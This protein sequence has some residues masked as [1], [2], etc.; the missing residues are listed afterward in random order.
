MVRP[1]GIGLD[2]LPRRKTALSIATAMREAEAA[3]ES[4]HSLHPTPGRNCGGCTSDRRP[5]G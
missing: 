1:Q 3:P 4:C 5:I 2:G